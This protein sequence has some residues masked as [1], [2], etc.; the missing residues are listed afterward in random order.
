M[1]VASDWSIVIISTLPNSLTRSR[2]EYFRVVGIIEIVEK[3]GRYS[4]ITMI[5]TTLKFYYL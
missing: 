4:T 1:C 5:P 2:G 3:I